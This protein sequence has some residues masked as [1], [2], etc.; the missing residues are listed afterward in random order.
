MFT[1]ASL[2]CRL[3]FRSSEGSW[4]SN[5]VR[6]YLCDIWNDDLPSSLGDFYDETLFQIIST[7]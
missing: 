3:V 4:A 2:L 1:V 7:D 6:V 5:K